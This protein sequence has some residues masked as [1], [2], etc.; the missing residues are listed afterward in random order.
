MESEIFLIFAGLS[1]FLDLIL[2]SQI[3]QGKKQ[4]NDYGVYAAILAFIL[5]LI[6]YGRF[7][8][9]FMSND[10]SFIGVYSYSSSGLSLFSKIYASWGGAGG[11]MLFLALILSIFYL[12]VRIKAYKN[13][14]NYWVF[15]T[16]I[17][18]II[19]LVFLIVSLVKNPFEQFSFTPIEGRG[20]NPQLQTFWMFIHPPIIFGAYAFVLLAFALTLSAMKNNRSFSDLK[21]L[22]S[23]TYAAWLLLS[24]GIALGGV[25][26][27]EVLGWGGYW[28][29]DPV[30]TA[31]LMP[32]LFL[33]SLFYLK[34]IAKSKS[35]SRE[36][37]ILLTFA[38]LVFLSALTRGGATQS[39][40]SYAI[41]PVGPIMMVFA[42]GMIAYFFYIRR[43]KS[44]P[45][46]KMESYRSSVHS[47]S[48]FII[49][50]ALILTTI[51]CF[52]G[53]AFQNFSYN[54]WAFPFVLALIVGIIGYS[55]NE[56]APFARVILLTISG[57]AAGFVVSQL[58]MSL[59]ILASLGIPLLILA[60]LMAA[61][62]LLQVSRK[63]AIN[64]FGL[65]M[66][67]LGIVVIL[68]GVFISAGAKTSGNITDVKL[69]SP[70]ENLGVII[71]VTNFS[72]GTRQSMVYYQ[73]L[74][75]LIPEYS[76]LEV[77]S[78]VQY[79]G[80]TYLRTFLADYYPNYGLV[81]RPQI[82]ATEVG[83]LYMHLEYTD[84]MSTSLVE[85]LREEIIIPDTVNIT[86]QTSPMIY[87]LWT[88]IAVMI[89]GIS[90]QLL[91]EL[92][93]AHKDTSEQLQNNR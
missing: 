30:E 47:R 9:A 42:V 65:S 41:S 11:S 45:L 1:L 89:L 3:K 39:V 44:Q 34:P 84:T 73:Q 21:L 38:S 43:S 54:Y 28:A 23:S 75:E 49:F 57:L 91:Y 18:N 74:D 51:V 63:K 33:T 81:L 87:L 58:H 29:W 15:T 88:G 86:I 50:W 10:F 48:A 70:V 24:V 20:L 82:I 40:H 66:I 59:H 79:M 77:E 68:L 4:K 61:S 64:H 17:L 76:F 93:L 22:K 85:A 56:K 31:S 32:W 19:L 37:M 80:K 8:H 67:N 55:L 35:F 27:Y 90:V 69:N 14:D 7:L 62:N 53:L 5:V 16:K 13:G 60:V 6:S 46:F 92:V 72:V 52:V 2:L 36:F 78:T 12:A 26:A 83:D 25:W 71:E